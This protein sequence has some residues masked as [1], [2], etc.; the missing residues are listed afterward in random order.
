MLD[1]VRFLYIVSVC[2]FFLM[3]R[4]PPRSTRTDTLL[5]YT[6]L[7]RS[8]AHLG[9]EPV[10]DARQRIFERCRR[11]VGEHRLVQR[12]Q[13]VVQRTGA[14]P[15]IRGAGGG[16]IG[17]QS[18]RDIGGDGDAARAAPPSTRQPQIGMADRK[19]AVEGKSVAG[20]GG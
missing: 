2:F 10:V 4:R 11:G 12:E 16:E 1:G 13:P 7:F 9:M 5:P 14:R 6:T 20:G 19:R 17:A 18:R 3:I 8:Q 15:V